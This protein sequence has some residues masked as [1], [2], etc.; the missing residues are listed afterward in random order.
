MGKIIGGVVVVVVLVGLFFWWN[1]KKESTPETAQQGEQTSTP[2]SVVP[3]E[4]GVVA[5][6][7]DAMGLGKKMQCIYASDANGK[8][9]QSTVMVDGQ[10]FKSTSVV[11]DMTVYAL[12][13]GDM[14]YTWTSKDKNGFKMSKACLDELKTA[15][16]T[17]E[18]KD[19]TAPKVE[20][21]EKSFDAA[22]N[23]SCTPSL[24]AD[25]SVP[26]DVVFVDQCAMMK[27]SLEMMKQYKDKLPAGM[28]IP[29][30]PSGN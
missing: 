6:I 1:G 3:K 11:G 18:T 28:T 27:Q 5:S 12:F 24:G 29:G 10:K 17:T 7:K 8:S 16:P 19:S 22:K 14:Q 30:V 2:G 9:F 26:T 25:F 13:D 23:V 21:P 15:L 4:S 20:D